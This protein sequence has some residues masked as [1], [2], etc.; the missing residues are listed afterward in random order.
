MKF[1][2]VDTHRFVKVKD[3][4]HGDYLES[5]VYQLHARL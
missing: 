3:L 1:L 2:Y 4:H 5:R